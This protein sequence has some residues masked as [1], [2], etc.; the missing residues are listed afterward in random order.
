MNKTKPKVL[1]SWIG[2]NDL[3]A[4]EGKSLE[5]IASPLEAAS[6]DKVE[7]LYSYQ[8][9]QVR[10]FSAWIKGHVNTVINAHPV[11]LSSPTLPSVRN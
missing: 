8:A 3:K 2:A 5:P 6:I 7:L 9:E 11:Q 1:L 4:L 10:P